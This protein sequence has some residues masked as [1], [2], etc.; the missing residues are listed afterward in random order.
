VRHH[1]EFR[2]TLVLAGAQPLE[3][4]VDE[5]GGH[6]DRYLRDDARGAVLAQLL[7]DQAQ[8]RERHRL[9]A[10]DAADTHAARADDVTGLPER[11][12]QALPR[13]LQEAEARQAADLDAGAIHLHRVAQPVL[14][15]ALVLGGLHVD[16]VD[17]DETA[18]ITDAQ[19][20]GDLVRG[21]QIGVGGGG[22]D[23][24]AA[25][26]ARGIDVDRYQS[27]RVIDDVSAYG[28]QLHLV[29][30]G[31]IDLALDLNVRE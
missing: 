20:P 1:Y 18:D 24:T 6:G 29:D 30:V 16:E 5:I 22:L 27:F 12:P 21:L 15:V 17:D 3:L 26:G 8:H 11:G 28:G 31:S 2:F 14:D 23:V 9:D 10:A 7:A 19:L 25:R 4:V 13:H